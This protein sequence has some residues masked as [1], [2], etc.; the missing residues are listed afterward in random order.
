MKGKDQ[1][2]HHPLN[3]TLPQHGK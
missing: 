3:R 2:M 1:N